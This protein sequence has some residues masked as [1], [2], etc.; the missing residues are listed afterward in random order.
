MG[1]LH[2][3]FCPRM[4]LSR[5]LRDHPSAQLRHHFDAKAPEILVIGLRSCEKRSVPPTRPTAVFLTEHECFSF[6][7]VGHACRYQHDVLSVSRNQNSVSFTNISFQSNTNSGF[8]VSANLGGFCPPSAL[9]DLFTNR[10][11]RGWF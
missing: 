1:L 2:S 4:I 9:Y 8:Y 6:P 3:R 10:A 7:P 5:S 11:S